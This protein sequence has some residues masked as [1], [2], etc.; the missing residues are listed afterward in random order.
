MAEKQKRR[1]FGLLRAKKPEPTG[2]T[3]AAEAGAL[4]VSH[5]RAAA[6]VRDAGESAQRIGASIAKQRSALVVVGDRARTASTRAQDLT[7]SFARV[8]AAFERLSLVALNAALEGARL[9]E[10]VGQSLQL[11]AEEV[12]LASARG[13]E[14]ARELSAAL[15]EVSSELALVTS[16]LERAHEASA[17]ITQETARVGSAAADTQRALGELAERLKRA[18]DTD[19]ETAQ[20]LADAV[21]HGRA[22]VDALGELG[23]RVPRGIL[24]GVLRPVLEPLSRWFGEEETGDDL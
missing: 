8:N 7:T 9:G 4:W 13:S 10:Q 2:A 22:F 12:R 23:E 19:P 17:E 18:T 24:V 20:A 16:G 15:H 3:S 5:G 1:L 21:E 14:S 6:G 11:V